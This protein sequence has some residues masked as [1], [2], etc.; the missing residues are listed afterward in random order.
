MEDAGRFAHAPTVWALASELCRA[1]TDE[2]G[3]VGCIVSRVIGDVLVQIAEHAPEGRTFHLGRGFLVSQFPATADVLA[4]RGARAVSLAEP[5]PDPAEAAVLRDLDVGA[6]LM[7]ALRG[8]AAAWGLVELYRAA[9]DAFAP[10][11]AELATAVVAE[12]ER[13]LAALLASR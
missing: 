4:G 12:A 11:D 13:A 3:G 9:P 7:L 10:A 6:V 8:P 5:D 1:L 2:I